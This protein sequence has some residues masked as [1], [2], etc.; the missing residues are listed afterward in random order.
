MSFSK[1][2]VAEHAFSNSH[3]FHDDVSGFT[4]TFAGFSSVAPDIATLAAG[5]KYKYNVQQANNKIKQIEV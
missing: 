2:Q 1:R 5:K 3:M 4:L